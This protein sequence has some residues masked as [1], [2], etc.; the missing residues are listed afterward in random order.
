MEY[1]KNMELIIIMILLLSLGL[2]IFGIFKA[3][4][5]S[6]VLGIIAFLFPAL[7]TTLG[8]VSLFKKNACLEIAEKLRLV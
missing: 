7:G 5:A 4:K 3:F 6:L 2:S 1:I 8:A